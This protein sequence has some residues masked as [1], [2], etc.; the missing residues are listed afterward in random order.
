MKKRPLKRG[1][2][3]LLAVCFLCAFCGLTVFAD[4]KEVH[5][6]DLIVTD[7]GLV[8]VDQNVE[9]DLLGAAAE[10]RVTG[11]VKGSIRVAASSLTLSGTVERNVT[12]AAAELKTADTLRA[13][14]VVIIGALAE[15]NGNFE[16]LTIY[17]TQVIFGGHV[18]GELICEA[19]QVIILEGATF[20]SAKITSQNEVVVATDA[21]LKN[22]KSL[23]ESSYAEKVEFTRALSDV[24]VALVS[25][26][27]TLPASLLLAWVAV[28]FMK[29]SAEDAAQAMRAK[30]FG[31]LIRGFL[32]FLGL[33]FGSA[34]LIASP[35][36]MS[37][38]FILLLLLIAVAIAGNAVTA[39]VLGRVLFRKRSPYV[40][41]AVVTV[42]LSAV[43]VLPYVSLVLFVP[44]A[45]V[46]FG[47]L[48]YVFSQKR[49]RRNGYAYDEP[50]FRL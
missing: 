34:F 43:S 38:G 24:T 50:D 3:V 33:L 45:A 12:V 6:G 47:T 23:S 48:Y 49:S 19:D 28:W 14:D 42:L 44:T 29:R 18:E 15:I 31:Y 2:G 9:G 27:Y 30:P 26:I 8:I 21:S 40:G 35:L 37:L 1:M 41:S 39:V 22:W 16:S 46:A 11:N 13:E 17:G 25:L 10:M 5:D 7:T 4:T 20:G 36:T 32:T